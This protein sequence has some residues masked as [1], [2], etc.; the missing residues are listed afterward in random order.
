TTSSPWGATRCP[1]CASPTGC[2]RRWDARFP[3]SCCS[4]I[5]RS[6]RSPATCARDRCRARRSNAAVTAATAA[7]RPLCSGAPRCAGRRRG[8][9]TWAEL[10]EHAAAGVAIIGLAG[11]FP[12]AATVEQLWRNLRQGTESISF[13]SDEELRAAG[14]DPALLADPCFVK[15]SPVLDG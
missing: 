6:L 12:G 9:T 4:S 1:W 7:A 14:V 5:R 10:R 11:R 2:A 3:C 15:A 8:R 13:F